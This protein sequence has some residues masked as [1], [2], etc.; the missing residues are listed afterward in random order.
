MTKDNNMIDLGTLMADL[1]KQGRVNEEEQRQAFNR[2]LDRIREEEHSKRAHVQGLLDKAID[3]SRQEEIQAR[4]KKIKQEQ[5]ELER[6]RQK[7]IEKETGIKS[8]ETIKQDEALK[9]MLDKLNK[10]LD[11]NKSVIKMDRDYN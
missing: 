9:G 4:D 2:R 7:Q 11:K 3:Q 1:E 8:D 5:E 10:K 6:E